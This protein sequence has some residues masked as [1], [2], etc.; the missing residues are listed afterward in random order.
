MYSIDL[1]ISAVLVWYVLLVI[2]ILLITLWAAIRHKNP[3]LFAWGAVMGTL[4]LWLHA[5]LAPIVFGVLNY[6][7]E[8]AP[9]LFV[10]T[11]I[12]AV[13][14]FGYIGLTLYNA[15]VKGALVA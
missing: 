5:Y 13:A 8:S 9:Y 14:W 2:G 1:D 10:L 6:S 12:F 7:W 3:A 15:V 11:G 4:I